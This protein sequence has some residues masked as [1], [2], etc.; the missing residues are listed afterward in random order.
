MTKPGEI[1]G[2]DKRGR[3]AIRWRDAAGKRHYKKLPAM[4]YA[5]V[6]QELAKR[7]ADRDKAAASE[8]TV[9]TIC[10]DYLE[11][12]D[13]YRKRPYTALGRRRAE[14]ISSTL[15]ADA[16]GQEVPGSMTPAQF[17]MKVLFWRG[18][19]ELVVSKATIDREFNFMRAAL[20][21]ATATGKLREPPLQRGAIVRLV[22]IH[23]GERDHFERD[24]W[25]RFITA[26]D[27]VSRWIAWVNGKR[28]FGPVK[29][30]A[31]IDTPRRYGAG[32]RGDSDASLAWRERLLAFRPLFIALLW[33][34][35]RL[36]EIRL[37]TWK[38][39]DFKKGEVVVPMG[40]V[41]KV[42]TVPLADDWRAD[43]ES[44]PRG[45]ADAPVY[46]S[47]DGEVYSAQAF[48]RAFGT[49]RDVAGLR[50]T[51]TVKATRHTALTWMGEAGVSLQVMQR[52]AGHASPLMTMRY[53]NLKTK[54][55]EV[56][57][58]ALKSTKISESATS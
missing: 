54:H 24:E 42:K 27:D 16:I 30:G 10:S 15:A 18:R 13:K 11:H 58:D 2:P 49:F 1:L 35:A 5:K 3:Y 34:V 39:V 17:L 40:K 28:R 22:N 14:G 31:A 41:G 44:R 21:F 55:L 48:A 50:S 19:R 43:L 51:L 36:S 38:H 23:D 32:M 6:K 9:A 33:G 46:P 4:P 53:V 37:L 7:I 29:I 52:L 47:A 57:I 20:L 45:I 12:H 25:Q 56:G 8:A 26:L